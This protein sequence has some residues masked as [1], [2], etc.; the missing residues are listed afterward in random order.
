M[1]TGFV[2]TFNSPSNIFTTHFV[3]L[4]TDL[5]V[6]THQEY[7]D[8]YN[9]TIELLPDILNLNKTN[10]SFVQNNVDEIIDGLDIQSV[11]KL[12]SIFSFIGQKYV[13]VGGR[14]NYVQELPF[15]IGY[16]WYKTAQ[17]LDI[18]CSCTY[19]SVILFNANTSGMTNASFE[20]GT[21]LLDTIGVNLNLSGTP[22]EINF[23][24]IHMA[25]EIA[26]GRF[27]ELMSKYRNQTVENI[28]LEEYDGL[29]NE[30]IRF[31]NIG[32]ELLN[33]MKYL[34]R[35][36]I[37]WTKI[38]IF[39]GGFDSKELFPNG[40]K[41]ELSDIVLNG[42]GGS[43]AQSTLM[44][45]FD[46]SFEISHDSN[47]HAKNI[48]QKMRTYMTGD[49]RKFLFTL[50]NISFVKMRDKY[51]NEHGITDKF[52]KCLEMFREF[53]TTHVGIVHSYIVQNLRTGVQTNNV[54]G[55]GGTSGLVRDV[56]GENDEIH[57][58]IKVLSGMATQTKAN[59]NDGVCE[60]HDVLCEHHD[61]IENRIEN[62]FGDC[63][64]WL[65]VFAM[66]VFV[67]FGVWV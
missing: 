24:K 56:V 46:Q 54:H 16:I 45:M 7:R 2:R 51:R 15:H 21:A 6:H 64:D 19:S 50:E 43:G 8:M 62:M 66:G 31:F 53:R 41:V 60:N 63:M 3:P 52:N 27:I 11:Q 17:R 48:I 57:P 14:E 42:T 18:P 47:P 10:M 13:W 55:Q 33:Q 36:D 20:N 67:I 35:T 37:F 23:F 58:L 1:N 34:C 49:D 40:L 26:G 59:F 29:L 38:R 4:I 28:T 25:I 44:Q 65:I 12:Y 30:T 9:R 61:G 32:N 5:H 39:L 22:D